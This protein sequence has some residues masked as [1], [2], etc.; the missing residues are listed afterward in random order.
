MLDDGTVSMTKVV[1]AAMWTLV[2]AL[3]L[4]SWGLGIAGEWNWAFLVGLTGCATSAAAAVAHIRCYALRV[5]ALVKAS[6]AITEAR[7]VSRLR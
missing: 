6:G 2:V 5:C 4:T 1:M 3:G 7:R